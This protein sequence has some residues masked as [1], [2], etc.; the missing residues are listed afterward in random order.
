LG[1][2]F[3][4][5][6]KYQKEQKKRGVSVIKS[7]KPD[8][9]KDVKPS[10]HLEAVATGPK[11]VATAVPREVA[12][13][14]PKEAATTVP[15][16]A[17]TAI[18]KEAAT[19]VL[20]DPEYIDPNLVV[21]SDP[22]SFEAEQFKILRTNILFPEV[23]DPPRSILVTSAVPG[24]GKSFVSANLAVSI[25]QNINEYVLLVDCDIRKP[26]VHGQFGFSEV[27]GLSEYLSSDLQLEP[28]LQKTEIDKLTILPGGHPPH[29]PSELLSSKKMLQLLVEI[30]A[31]YKDRYIIIDSPPPKLTAETSAIARHVDGII[32]VVRYGKTS[33]QDVVELIEKV[34]KRKLLGTIVNRC[35][36]WLPGYKKYQEYS[37]YYS[38]A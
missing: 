11:E 19:A 37:K 6:E 15:M 10:V 4:A 30:K 13:A 36:V 34:G 25:A 32:L 28:L 35:D 33:R 27:N 2:V 7:A 18:P 23:G 26:S 29:N 3:K 38:N 9:G 17:A 1:K 5:L 14:V 22:Q 24:E 31:R 16:E 8:I 12:T 21:L 20:H